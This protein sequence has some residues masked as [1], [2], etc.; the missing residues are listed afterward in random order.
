MLQLT[1][2]KHSKSK[3]TNCQRRLQRINQHLLKV[4]CSCVGRTHNRVVLMRSR[5]WKTLKNLILMR[6]VVVVVRGR[7]TT[8]IVTVRM[9]KKGGRR[10]KISSLNRSKYQTKCSVESRGSNV[11]RCCGEFVESFK[12]FS[13]NP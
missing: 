3:P 13:R 1:I 10:E 6:V 8:V 12:Q 9:M 4:F 5:E 7:A 2:C 11:V